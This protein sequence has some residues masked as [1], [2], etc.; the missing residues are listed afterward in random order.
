MN[1]PTQYTPETYMQLP[2]S[3]GVYFFYDQ[4]N[5]ILYVGKAKSLRSRVGQ[6]FQNKATNRRLAL[7]VS[8]IHHLHVILTETESDALILENSMIKKHKP[9]YNILLKD[10]KTYPYICLTMHPYPRL[11]ITRRRTQHQGHYYGPYTNGAHVRRVVDMLQK[12][13]RLRTCANS[14]FNNRSR[15]CLLY[16][17]NRCSGP[18][19]DKIDHDAYADAVAGAKEVLSGRCER[20]M[21]HYVDAMHTYSAAQNYEKAAEYRDMLKLLQDFMQESAPAHGQRS[22]DII[23]YCALN[24]GFLLQVTQYRDSV[25][26]SKRDYHFPDATGFISDLLQQFMFQYYPKDRIEPL[27]HVVLLLARDEQL[28]IETL[29]DALSLA[30]TIK[31]KPSTKDEKAFAQAASINLD[32]AISRFTSQSQY[33]VSAFTDLAACFEDADWQ[34]IDCVDI[35]HIQGK[36]TTAAC[37]RFS[38]SG[39]VK[40]EY[41]SYNLTTG[42]DDYASMRAFIQKRFASSSSLSSPNLL[43]IDGGRG[44]LSSVATAMEEAGVT[45]IHLLAICKAPG[46][47]S[48]E[49]RYFALSLDHGVT[50]LT[51][52][53]HV[54]RMLENIRDHAHRLAITKQRQK[55]LKT[56]LDSRFSEVPGLGPKRIKQLMH[57]FGGLEPITKASVKQLAQVPGISRELAERI[58]QLCHKD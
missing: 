58:Y 15:P 13:L 56:S 9:K 41:R 51:L 4:T 3:P 7:L 2:A 17:I 5:T 14:Y 10:D 20:L 55:H 57:Y 22:L 35:S 24:Q 39:P 36:H 45:R 49:E 33:Y 34:I 42:N 44:Q 54:T 50:Q 40:S 32:H 52:P 29:D 1:D 53:A 18:C 38:D 8:Q 16:Q 6:Y 47:R 21:T 43:L 11:T 37:V 48:G 46:R 12:L 23:A 31:Y 28:Q 25:I 27:P 19:V 26:A 30:T